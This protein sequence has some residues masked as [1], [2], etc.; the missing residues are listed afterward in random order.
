MINTATST[1]TK[2]LISALLR[3]VADKLERNKEYLA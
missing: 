3:E 1:T 2:A